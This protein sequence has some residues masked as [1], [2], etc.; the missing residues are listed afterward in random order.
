M[1]HATSVLLKVKRNKTLIDRELG[2]SQGEFRKSIGTIEGMFNISTINERSNLMKDKQRYACLCFID[3]E[4]AFD[5]V[6]YE[7]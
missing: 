2:N 5:R 6:N 4:K 7:K 3:Y 1:S